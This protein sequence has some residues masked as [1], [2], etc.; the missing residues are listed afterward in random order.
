MNVVIQ[1][2]SHLGLKDLTSLRVRVLWPNLS[3]SWVAAAA[4]AVN[5]ARGRDSLPLY[6]ALRC[7]T[8]PSPRPPRCPFVSVPCEKRMHSFA[9]TESR[10]KVVRQRPAPL[11]RGSQRSAGGTQGGARVRLLAQRQPVASRPVL[12]DCCS[13]PS[14]VHPLTAQ[15]DTCQRS[16]GRWLECW[17]RENG[18]D[19]A[20]AT[21][22]M[23]HSI[24]REG[25]QPG[26]AT[27]KVLFL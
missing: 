7:F 13:C 26:G 3:L 17:G 25:G 16:P 14:R 1:S 11:Q 5:G 22:R 15:R 23:S 10:S 20:P 2:S 21:R 9:V 4:A 18:P 19:M 24:A 12:L 27:R 6:A 8:P